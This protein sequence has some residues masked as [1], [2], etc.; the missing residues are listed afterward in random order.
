MSDDRNWRDV[1][2]SF[3]KKIVE[4]DGQLDV[5]KVARELS[6]YKLMLDQVPLVYAHVSGGLLSKPFYDAAAVIRIAEENVRQRIEWAVME[7]HALW[8]AGES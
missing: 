8:E 6:D 4:T 1:Y 3:W 5:D 2:D 7:A